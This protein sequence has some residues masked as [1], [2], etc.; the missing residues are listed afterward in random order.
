M[1][2]FG[3]P[4]IPIRAGRTTRFLW[5]VYRHDQP[6][7]KGRTWSCPQGPWLLSLLLLSISLA[8][9]L[10]A[11][12]LR[13][14]K[15]ILLLNS[16]HQG[17][18][19]TDDE[20]R[21]VLS[22]LAPQGEHTKVYT[23]YMGMKWTSD[24]AY[25]TQLKATYKQKFAAIPFDVII[26]TDNDAF[27]FLR[28][29][30]DEV[31]GP[32]PTVFC[33]VNYFQPEALQGHQLYTG[34]SETADFQANLDL[35]LELHPTTRRIA[36]I[37]DTSVTG[38]QV[39]REV[40]AVVPRY[41]HRLTFDFLTDLTMEELRRRVADLPDDAL[42]LFTFF[43]R[44]K[45]GRLFE[46]DESAAM[47]SRA[48]QVP[49][50]GT[51]DFSLGYGIIGG[52]LTNGFEQGNR[53]AELA[54]RILRGERPQDIPVVMRSPSQFMFDH[55]QMRRFHIDPGQLPPESVIINRPISS[56][57]LSKRVVWLSG[58]GTILLLGLLVALLINIRQHKAARKELRASEEQYRSLVDNLN[59][60]I[61]RD[62][63]EPEGRFLQ[64]NPAMVKLFGYED[65]ASFLQTPVVELYDRPGDR[66]AYLSE[67]TRIGFVKDTQLQMKTRNA[68][69][70]WVSCS[71]K[72]VLDAQGSIRWIDGVL[73][74]I[75]EKKR[76]EEQLWQAQKMES[77][78]ALAGGIAHDFNNI[79][80]AISGYGTLLKA[81][82]GHDPALAHLLGPILSSAE[83]AAQLTQ[84][85][86]AFS[87]KQVIDPKPLNLN[88]V[89]TGMERLLARL[90]GEDIEL[91]LRLS[92]HELMIMADKSQLEQILLNLVTNA[93]D[94]MPEGGA[95]S[96]GSRSL[97][98]RD[99]A[100]LL[101]HEFKS[102]GEY[103]VLSVTDSGMGMDEA[104]RQRI[105][106]PFFTTKDTGRGTGLGLAIAHGIVKQ[107]GGDISVDSEPDKG[108][109]FSVYLPLIP[110]GMHEPL[111]QSLP[112]AAGGTETILLAE[113]DALVRQWTRQVLSQAGYTVIE[114]VNGEELVAKFQ[115]ADH[116]DL[117]LLDVVMP[118][119]NG[120]EA[121]D[122]IRRSH[123][124]IKALFT[125]GYTADIIHRKGILDQDINF[126]AKPASQ[127]QLLAKIRQVLAG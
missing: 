28:A 16:Y 118:R 119:K 2:R 22:V 1:N 50:Y 21:G 106:E 55:K 63:G 25:F 29:H 23:E 57:T 6:S 101:Q 111:E 125:S 5:A 44:D 83:K 77:I 43:F 78:G 71:A 61:Y 127:E 69:S 103:A 79:L 33:G 107:H 54:A 89:I 120:R 27:N 38:Q 36:V 104:T 92:T 85:L 58:A 75:S 20:T 67:L 49:V 122:E 45:D 99:Q 76:L 51:W 17:Y 95:I 113:D 96:I 39:L 80:T 93:R 68:T 53:A 12:Q 84:S 124:W 7:G 13:Q 117:I 114:A 108:T 9:P 116:V 98:L 65:I 90:I 109:T 34:V 46:H 88:E 11:E 91:H 40:S 115:A 31:F 47:V 112:A 26:A 64:A 42:V 110:G 19:W 97:L 126:L 74:D 35:L 18:K 70:I 87:R 105:F 62:N 30:R 14:H 100:S 121:L 82:V 94:A 24:P 60:G 10:R 56:Y 66:T 41:E 123:P 59:V 72:A 73:E 102:P 15:N 32:T 48:S 81:K 86:L 37:I 4:T 3:N 8:L 52:K